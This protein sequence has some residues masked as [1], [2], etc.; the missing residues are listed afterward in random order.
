MLIINNLI[1]LQIKITCGEKGFLAD[2]CRCFSPKNDVSLFPNPV[3][4]SF[5][6]SFF[7]KNALALL[8]PARSLRSVFPLPVIIILDTNVAG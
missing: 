8:A 3:A 4:S 7:M 1:K 2:V 5:K 6:H